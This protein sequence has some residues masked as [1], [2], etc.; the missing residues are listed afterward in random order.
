MPVRRALP[1]F[2]GAQLLGAAGGAVDGD[3][4]TVRVAPPPRLP[5]RADRRPRSRP[6]APNTARARHESA[7]PD[8]RPPAQL[9]RGT[10]DGER[11]GVSGLPGTGAMGVDLG[12]A[13]NP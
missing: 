6:P 9:D 12:G 10:A 4:R 8:R 5:G 1:R 2:P 7:G 11:S 13:V 3:P